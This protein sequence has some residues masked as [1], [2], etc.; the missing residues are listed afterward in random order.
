MKI[1][2]GFLI[3]LLILLILAL[4]K[5][6][7]LR[8]GYDEL[9]ENIKDQISGDT[10]V[11]ITLTTSDSKARNCAEVLNAELKSLR[12]E[13]LKF[14]GGNQTIKDAVTG[15]SHDLRTPLTSINAYLDLIEEEGDE[16]KKKEYL[17]RVKKRTGDL[18]LLTEELFKYTTSSDM[19]SSAPSDSREEID[20]KR[21]LEE[22]LISFY[23]S[24]VSKGIEP[25]INMPDSPVTALCS[26]KDCNRIL[27][28]I[29]GNAI[30]YSEGDLTI[31]LMENAAIEFSN[32]ASSLTPLTV[33]KLFDKYYTV[34]DAEGSTG[35]GFAIAKD[36]IE[37]NSGRIEAELKN[38]NLIIKLFFS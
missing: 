10:G 12:D 4:L 20:L 30:K 27:E 23:A 35:L 36:L 5:I 34:N 6:Y 9:T 19:S 38:Q 7:D 25:H 15:I 11:P 3:L 28:N 31:T 26:K 1:L 8:K 2:I 13:R 22:C 32:P 17:A 16:T 24:F 37:K 14:E 29:I 18:S 33:S 21:T